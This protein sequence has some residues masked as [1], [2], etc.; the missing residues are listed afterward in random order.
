MRNGNRNHDGR[1]YIDSRKARKRN[2][3]GRNPD[4]KG[5]RTG[6]I[7]PEFYDLI[8]VKEIIERSVRDDGIFPEGDFGSIRVYNEMPTPRELQRLKEGRK[9]NGVYYGLLNMK[10][11]PFYNEMGDFS[12]LGELPPFFVIFHERTYPT[13]E[14]AG[15]IVEIHSLEGVLAEV[16]FYGAGKP[17]GQEFYSVR[18]IGDA[19]I[20]KRS[21]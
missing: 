14:Q 15:L 10:R 4:K 20:M 7:Y 8:R 2:E 6:K 11:Y 5:F 12:S 1:I 18:I 19:G 13:V 17:R 16:F 21:C 9:L 3:V